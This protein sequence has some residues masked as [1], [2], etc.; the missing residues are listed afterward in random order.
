VFPLRD[1][2]FEVPLTGDS[3]TTI[4][5]VLP[6]A[7]TPVVA[8]TSKRGDAEVASARH[9]TTAVPLF[10]IVPSRLATAGIRRALIFAHRASMRL[11]RRASSRTIA[12]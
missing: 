3:C 10:E 9:S 8:M 2:T 12:P 1:H 7:T 4:G 6:D 11:V 5:V